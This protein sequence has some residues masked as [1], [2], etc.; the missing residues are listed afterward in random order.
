MLWDWCFSM[1]HVQGTTPNALYQRWSWTSPAIALEWISEAFCLSPEP[2]RKLRNGA[3]TSFHC[4]QETYHPTY[5][6]GV[7]IGQLVH[8]GL[9]TIADAKAAVREWN[10]TRDARE[11]LDAANAR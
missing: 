5:G 6:R 2:A 3:L 1:A 4:S 7:R 9:I 11:R 10:N 8:E